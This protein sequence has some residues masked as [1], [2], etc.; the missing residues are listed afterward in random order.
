MY[1]FPL[2]IPYGTNLTIAQ[3]F[4]ADSQID[5]S[6]ALSTSTIFHNGVDIVSGNPQQSW[7]LDCVWP[8]PWPGT[9]FS[10][11]VDSPFGALLHAH[12]QV[13]T[14]NPETGTAYSLIYLH[15]S[16][17]PSPKTPTQDKLITYY[18]GDTVAKTGNNG[19]VTPKPT[20]Q[21][22]YDGT[23]LHL[24]L[25]VKRPGELN[26]IMADPLSIFDIN[27]PFR[28]TNQFIFTKDLFLGMMNND[29]LELQKRL[30]IDY[31]TGPGIFGPKTFSAVKAYQAIHR[32]PQT[33]YVGPLTR[34]SLNG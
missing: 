27:D 5:F 15:V 7:G 24:G 8:F 33:G 10:A 9:V 28:S 14:V 31:T 20:P 21:K 34:A 19:A 29:V 17:V 30:G 1:R 16:S 6:T 32:V 2:R 18:L 11:E 4:R 12:T 13:D 26:F 22:P 25:G 23:H 3:P